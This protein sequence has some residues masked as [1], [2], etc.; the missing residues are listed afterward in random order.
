LTSIVAGAF[1]AVIGLGVAFEIGKL[2]AV[3]WLGHRNGA[4]TLRLA[5]A[6]L[7][8]VLMLLNSIGVYGFLSRAHIEHPL[9]GD[10]RVANA[11]ATIDAQLD[12]K[13]ADL[14][15]I[16]AGIA[17]LDQIKTVTTKGHQKTAAVGDQG[18]ARDK[19]V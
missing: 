19:L 13:Q 9:A 7:V 10:Q 17:Q 15:G 18:P 5:L 16:K 3:A 4:R 14:D 1:W 11:S 12:A 2:S 6:A 8:A